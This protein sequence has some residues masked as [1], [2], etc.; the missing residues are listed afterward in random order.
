MRSGDGFAYA[1]FERHSG[2][3][4]TADTEPGEGD[5]RA[6]DGDAFADPATATAG[7]PSHFHAQFKDWDLRIL[8]N[9]PQAVAPLRG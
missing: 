9:L 4:D 6:A 8:R 1:R 3:R 5:G 2:L 7:S